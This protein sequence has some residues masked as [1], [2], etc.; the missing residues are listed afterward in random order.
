MTKEI[1][2]KAKEEKS[3]YL[4]DQ[5]VTISGVFYH[6]GEHK[7]SDKEH[8]ELCKHEAIAKIISLKQ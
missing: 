4:F 7:L 1:A 8:A 5:A 3:S 6:K 2:P